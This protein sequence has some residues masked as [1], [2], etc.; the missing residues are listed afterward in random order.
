MQKAERSWSEHLIYLRALN[1]AAGGG[2]ERLILDNIANHADP[3]ISIKLAAKVDYM[4]NYILTHARELCD[5]AQRVG[6]E[7]M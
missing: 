2:Q 3:S 4:R 7:Q 5:Y 1:E 6:K